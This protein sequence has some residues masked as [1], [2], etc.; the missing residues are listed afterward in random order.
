MI[1]NRL[2]G[3]KERP[4]SN[5][6]L[7]QS[8]MFVDENNNEDLIAS[9]LHVPAYI[10]ASP[11]HCIQL[12]ASTGCAFHKKDVYTNANP[13]HSLLGAERFRAG[14]VSAHHVR[15]RA[16]A[17]LYTCERRLRRSAGHASLGRTP[18]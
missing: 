15:A 5:D 6:V 12:T 4:I 13:L 16:Y 3:K 11:S 14:C 9:H 7:F 8:R 2:E 18:V 17:C 10:H 1:H